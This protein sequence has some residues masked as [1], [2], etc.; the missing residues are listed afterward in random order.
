M[1][2]ERLGVWGNYKDSPSPS[3]AAGSRWFHPPNASI[4]ESPF[5][6]GLWGTFSNVPAEGLRELPEHVC[7]VG[8]L[9]LG[10]INNVG[11][12]GSCVE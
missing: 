12:N 1:I 5:G 11:H 9:E 10:R 6:F 7:F 3:S 8:Q 4:K 2:D